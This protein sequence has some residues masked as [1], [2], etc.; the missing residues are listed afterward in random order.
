MWSEVSDAQILEAMNIAQAQVDKII[1]GNNTGSVSKTDTI[2]GDGETREYEF[3]A[4]D[5]TSITSVTVDGASLTE[6]THYHLYKYPNSDYYWKIVFET[7]P[8]ND[9]RNIVIVYDHGQ[10]SDYLVN[11]LSNLLASRIVVLQYVRS[12]KQSGQYVRGKNQTAVG[13]TTRLVDINKQIMDI[14]KDVDRRLKY[15][16]AM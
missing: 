1:R 13:N 14:V 6:T 7:P 12:S 3:E 4:S 11:H 16:L 10:S 15:R 9:F 2:D 5:V 8:I